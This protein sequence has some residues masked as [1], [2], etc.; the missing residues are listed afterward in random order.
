MLSGQ[1]VIPR[2]VL[3][4]VT[5]EQLATWARTAT[6]ELPAPL[7]TS[8][9]DD[10]TAIARN[11]LH[12]ALESA[13]GAGHCAR[14]RADPPGRVNVRVFTEAPTRLCGFHVDTVPAGAPPVGAL[15]VYNGPCTEYVEP[16]DVRDTESFYDYLARRERLSHHS[17][18]GA[19][20][21]SD[22]PAH[23]WILG[24]PADPLGPDPLVRRS[25][26]ARERTH[27]ALVVLDDMPSFL[28]TGA[29]VKTVPPDATVYFRHLD[30]RHMWSAYP[31]TRTW[32]HRS[33]MA[34][35]TRLVVN[36]ALAGRLP[37]RR[38]P[39]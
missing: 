9:V 35:P 5:P 2:T 37:T 22:E 34:G 7:A 20:A 15:R 10:M 36:I 39:A 18:R 30:V 25:E 31:V 6:L 33:P 32:I 8:L 16:S 14:S 12:A 11:V 38:S 13:G 23:P 28:R 27:A 21:D 19:A 26:L 4:A 1:L 17:P 24:E 3:P 29:A